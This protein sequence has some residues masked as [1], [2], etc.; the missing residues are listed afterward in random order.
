MVRAPIRAPSPTTAN[1]ADAASAATIGARL[2]QRAA[3]AR[4]AAGR[5]PS[6]NSST[7]RANARYGLAARSIAQ[8][9]GRPPARNHRRRARARA[10]RRRTWGWRRRSGRRGRPPR[11]PRRARS[12]CRRR[13]RAAVESGAA[14]FAQLH[15][16][17][18]GALEEGDEVLEPQGRRDGVDAR[19]AL[20]RRR[21]PAP[22]AAPSAARSARAPGDPVQAPAARPIARGSAR[23]CGTRSSRRR[24]SGREREEHDAAARPS[25]PSRSPASCRCFSRS[26]PS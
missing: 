16:G 6:A 4:P 2:D 25:A 18:R 19:F 22:G 17:H 21:A 13:P 24:G 5:Q 9:A 15:V 11:C 14:R 12:R 20:L 7:A 26:R 3:G 1:G 23:P 8:G 10:A